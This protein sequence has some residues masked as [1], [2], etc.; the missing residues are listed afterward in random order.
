MSFITRRKSIDLV[1]QHEAHERLRPTLS[2]PHLVALGVGGIVG[3]GI[4]TLVGV[5]A[6]LAGPGVILS[7]AIAGVVCA[8]AALAYAEM[9]TMMPAAGSAYTYSY[10]V[11]GELIAWVVGWALMMEYTVV[12]SAVSVGWSA[13]AAEFLHG[14]GLGIPQSL[15]A[16]P[17]AGGLVNLPAVV[18]CLAVAGLLMLGTRESA[19]VNVVLVVIKVAALVAFIVIAA[20][21]F[22]PAH[23]QPFAPFGYS[24]VTA[25]GMKL[26]II[27]AASLIFFA[28]YGFDA[29]STAAEEAKNP[30][31]DLTIGIIGSMVVCT[32]I[33]MAV[34][35]AAIG[36]TAPA[37]FASSEA[38]L[39]FVLNSLKQP[40]VAKLV[41][42]AAVLALPT[43]IMVFMYGQ[44]RI[45]FVMARDGLLPQ[46][47]A[48]VSSRTGTPALMTAVTGLIAAG[49]AGLLPLKEIAELA[50][51]GT[52]VAFI[53]V[54]VC[55]MILRIKEPGRPRAFKTP[56]WW[57]VGP[58]AIAGCVYLFIS[59]P[60]VTH[61]WFLGVS[62]AGLVVY[63]LYGVRKSRLARA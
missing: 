58:L 46:A 4:Y 13:H 24:Q 32:V 33:Y 28:F 47:L 40:F 62:A 14:A 18:I 16:G 8:C 53:A 5:G 23:F 54:A 35:A 11:L 26:G 3:T 27:P 17:G 50:N 21:A 43:V 39:V 45:F 25:D 1:T 9:S 37:A 7:F 49:I 20:P 60:D 57:L 41:A 38:P 2:W 42:G 15:L 6:G 56:L 36:A 12:C 48:K 30:G 51:A 44:S 59:L 52:L 63:L 34:A 29:I 22:D 31:R 61:R 10:A 19:T 55:M